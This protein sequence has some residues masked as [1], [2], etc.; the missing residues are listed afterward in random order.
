[1]GV[2]NITLIE[3]MLMIS[4]EVVGNEWFQLSFLSSFYL[5]YFFLRIVSLDL[6]ATCFCFCLISRSILFG[7]SE[8][9]TRATSI[10]ICGGV[11]DG[12]CGSGRG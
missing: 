1:M 10:I 12:I 3:V 2:D 8:K 7:G 5:L 9:R 6:D 11:V 4:V